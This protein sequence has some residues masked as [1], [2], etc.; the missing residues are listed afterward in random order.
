MSSCAWYYIFGSW[1]W[2]E[3]FYLPRLSRKL[4]HR[5]SGH[6]V[7][8]VFIRKVRVLSCKLNDKSVHSACRPV[9]LS[10]SLAVWGEVFFFMVNEIHIGPFWLVHSS[11]GRPSPVLRRC[12]WPYGFGRI[13]KTVFNRTTRGFLGT[14]L[15]GE[16]SFAFRSSHIFFFVWFWVVSLKRGVKKRWENCERFIAADSFF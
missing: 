13:W 3:Q 8:S 12:I 16:W 7:L 4:P 15:N 11:G 2:S 1:N 9:V 14:L 10:S 6:G 5:A